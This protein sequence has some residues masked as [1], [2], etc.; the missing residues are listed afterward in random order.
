MSQVLGSAFPKNGPT[1]DVAGAVEQLTSTLGKMRD[2]IKREVVAEVR[3]ELDKMVRQF[4]AEMRQPVVNVAAP[5][6]DA[7][8]VNVAAPSIHVDAI[9]SVPDVVV[10]V[11]EQK[12]DGPRSL[13]VERDIEGNIVRVVVEQ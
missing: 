13:R 10:H 7:P 4:L 8:A 6:V 5:I 11:P 9:A 12:R 1:A 2:E 3:A